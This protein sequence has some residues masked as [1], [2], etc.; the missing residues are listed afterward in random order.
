MLLHF[1]LQISADRTASTL[2]STT[3]ASTF[4]TRRKGNLL[5]G[6]SPLQVKHNVGKVLTQMCYYDIA[7]RQ[8]IY[9]KMY[10][11]LSIKVL[12]FSN[13]WLFWSKFKFIEKW[14]MFV[15]L[16][17]YTSL[18]RFINQEFLKSRCTFVLE[19]FLFL[20]QI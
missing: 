11:G 9:L 12:I 1:L 2:T 4:Q 18:P 13:Y 5:K 17:V 16:L 3:T 10:L 20:G 15:C 14:Q 7:I 19:Y 6:Y 8:K